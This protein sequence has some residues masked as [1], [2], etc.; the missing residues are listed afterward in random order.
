MQHSVTHQHNQALSMIWTADLSFRCLWGC[1]EDLNCLMW[2]L[3][4]EN[5]SHTHQERL[6]GSDQP[7]L[8]CSEMNVWMETF[9]RI[10][11]GMKTVSFCC[12][13]PE[14]LLLAFVGMFHLGTPG[15]NSLTH[16]A[17]WVTFYEQIFFSWRLEGGKMKIWFHYFSQSCHQ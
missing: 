7:I 3:W 14:V 1:N 13:Y 8:V 16:C 9:K 6:F 2:R 10:L 5:V 11:R 15:L 12:R 17:L 4:F